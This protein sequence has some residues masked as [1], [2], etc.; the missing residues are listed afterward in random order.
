MLRISIPAPWQCPR[1]EVAWELYNPVSTFSVKQFLFLPPIHSP[2]PAALSI[3]FRYLSHSARSST[4]K[5]LLNLICD[6]H[7]TSILSGHI[8]RSSSGSALRI[9]G[10]HPGSCVRS[11]CRGVLHR[12]NKSCCFYRVGCWPGG[13]SSFSYFSV[14]LEI[15]FFNVSES[16][17]LLSPAAFLTGSCGRTDGFI[18]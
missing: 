13:A 14:F 6:G 3:H 8:P 5:T 2:L 12:D 1:L 16:D 7:D 10:A 4:S 9:Y 17:T 11:S 15:T 18:C